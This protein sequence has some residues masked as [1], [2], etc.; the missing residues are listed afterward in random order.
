[1]SELSEGMKHTPQNTSGRCCFFLSKR[2]TKA[3]DAAFSPVKDCSA[4]PPEQRWNCE[5]GGLCFVFLGSVPFL[6]WLC[7]DLFLW[8][9]FC[10]DPF[11][12]I[13]SLGLVCFEDVTEIGNSSKVLR[14]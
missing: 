11:S 3:T 4:V 14:E 6:F 10:W 9:W 1:M 2:I 13:C 8:L 5:T 12:G 7:W